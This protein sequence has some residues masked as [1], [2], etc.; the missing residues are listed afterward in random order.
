[1]WDLRNLTLKHLGTE[2]MKEKKKQGCF[3]ATS[4]LYLY[5]EL[6]NL[7]SCVE[8]KLNCM[9]FWLYILSL[10]PPFP[11][12]SPFS[13]PSSSFPSPSP[14]SF[15]IFSSSLLDSIYYLQQMILKKDHQSSNCCE[16]CLGNYSMY[17]LNYEIYFI[18]TFL[19]QLL[20]SC[21]NKT[22]K[23]W[24]D[25]NVVKRNGVSKSEL[26]KLSNR[27]AQS[28]P[29]TIPYLTSWTQW[30]RGNSQISLD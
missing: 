17:Y 15:L 9:Y 2:K 20:H 28:A 23:M 27:F 1:M 7:A 14:H 8:S 18:W 6:I 4:L 19:W 12:P 16:P 21:K 10:H 5:H 26:W 3:L 25:V 13:T 29:L 22:R 24:R 11:S 30:T